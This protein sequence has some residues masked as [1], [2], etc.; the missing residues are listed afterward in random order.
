M[1]KILIII[2]AKDFQDI[3]YGIPKELFE[4]A[5]FKVVTASTQKSCLGVFGLSVKAD[6]LLEEI[7]T[8]DFDAIVLI[9][10]GGAQ[11]FIFDAEIHKILNNFYNAGKLVASI[12]LS[13]ATL[14]KAGLLKGKK[15]T[16]FPDA[17]LI[18]ILESEGAKYTG[19]PVEIDGRII[20]AT[21]PT[22]AEEFAKAIISIS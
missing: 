13:P 22:A 12:C 15:A 9:G 21:D 1:K 11:D 19:N 2:A 5:G 14:A 10:G 17:Q 6:L 20:T 7:K 3:E 4:Q 16:V 18:S 8:S